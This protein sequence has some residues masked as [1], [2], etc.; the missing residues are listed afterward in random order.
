MPLENNVLKS[1][2]PLYW[3][4]SLKGTSFIVY[5]CHFKG[6]IFLERWIPLK[7]YYKS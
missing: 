4:V 2:F 3:D 7:Y 6:Q 1:T 5:Y